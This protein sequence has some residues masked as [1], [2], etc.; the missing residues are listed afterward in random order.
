MKPRLN[1]ISGLEAPNQ[2]RMSGCF[3]ASGRCLLSVA[4]RSGV[5]WKALQHSG[6]P[7]VPFCIK[8]FV[9]YMQKGLSVVHSWCYAIPW[10]NFLHWCFAYGTSIV[11]I[12]YGPPPEY[13]YFIL[14]LYFVLVY[15]MFACGQLF[16]ATSYIAL[17]N[18]WTRDSVHMSSNESDHGAWQ[19]CSRL[20]IARVNC[21]Q[22]A[23]VCASDIGKL[24]NSI[25]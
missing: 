10:Q 11:C 15:I 18:G 2:P 13:H 1:T 14:C 3:V 20:L 9:C 8:P 17:D 5:I 24:A 21:P 19:L 12:G 22:I 4:I 16:L 6:S 25:H 23:E 7:T